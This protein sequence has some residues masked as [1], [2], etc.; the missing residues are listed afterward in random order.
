[1]MRK[2]PAGWEI[3]R[4]TNDSGG[5][6]RTTRIL[7]LHHSMRFPSLRFRKFWILKLWHIN[8]IFWA[9]NVVLFA[10]FLARMPEHLTQLWR[11]Y[12][13]RTTRDIH[14]GQECQ[15]FRK[16]TP[17]SCFSKNFRTIMWS[18]FNL[19]Q[20]MSLDIF[21]ENTSKSRHFTCL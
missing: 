2:P 12:I 15:H 3:W 16:I 5:E 9:Q 18:T 13:F 14:E 21:H 1:M 8:L 10:H 20:K 4:N 19:L 6:Y 17:T 11:S 7:P